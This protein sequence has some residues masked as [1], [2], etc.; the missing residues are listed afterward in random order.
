MLSNNNNNQPEILQSEI[1]REKC[2]NMITSYLETLMYD[3]GAVWKNEYGRIDPT[4][5]LSTTLP[6]YTSTDEF[7][8]ALHPSVIGDVMYYK[9]LPIGATEDNCAFLRNP[10]KY[11]GYFVDENAN[12][13]EERL[14]SFDNAQKKLYKSRVSMRII[15]R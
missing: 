12:V 13:P 4:N 6:K 9:I 11:D 15:I 1:T 14:N 10:D 2:T 8:V 3:E 7:F 5:E